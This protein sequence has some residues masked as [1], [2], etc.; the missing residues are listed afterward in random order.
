M[1]ILVWTKWIDD[2][3]LGTKP[4]DG[5]GGAEVQ[6]AYWAKGLANSGHKVYSFG[7]RFKSLFGQLYGVS[8]LFIPWLRKIGVLFNPMRFVYLRLLKPDVVIVRSAQDFLKL[9]A[10]KSDIDYKLVYMI[11][12]DKN[13][14]K[15]YGLYETWQTHLKEADLVV[16]Q[17]SYQLKHLTENLE[18]E[19]YLLQP[20]IFDVNL[21]ELEPTSKEVYDFIW[22][23]NLK[24]LKRPDWFIQLAESLPNYS[25]VMAGKPQEAQYASEAYI[26]RIGRINNLAYKGYVSLQESV[27]LLS[28]SRVLVNTSE[29]EGFPNTYIQAHALNKGIIGTIDPSNF[30][31]RE[32]FYSHVKDLSDL[33]NQAPTVLENWERNRLFLNPDNSVKLAIGKME[34]A[35]KY[36]VG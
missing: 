3:F 10:M 11:A 15:T 20:N 17:N 24:S 26:R 25:F 18:A 12:S 7:W 36:L 34:N 2:V 13:I 35:L 23:G 14:E 1:K 4:P 31:E 28:S 19:N 9:L 30:F 22:L 33:I 29:F 8:F 5:I 16:A 27:Q 6:L 32:I 21:F